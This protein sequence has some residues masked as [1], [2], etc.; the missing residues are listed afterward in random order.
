MCCSSQTPDSARERFAFSDVFFAHRKRWERPALPPVRRRAVACQ[1]GVRPFL[2]SRERE[3]EAGVPANH[4]T[5][6]AKVLG[7]LARAQLRRA[8]VT[9]GYANV[10]NGCFPEVHGSHEHAFVVVKRTGGFRLLDEPAAKP[11]TDRWRGWLV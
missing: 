3:A 8:S 9:V 4:A 10:S 2:S 7:F 5:A 11:R 6:H 1:R